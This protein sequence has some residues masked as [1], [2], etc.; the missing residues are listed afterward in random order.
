MDQSFIVNILAHPDDDGP[1]LVFADWLEEQGECARSEFIR[2]QCE[3]AKIG[4]PRIVLG[5]ESDFHNTDEDGKHHCH[6]VSKGGPDYY[7]ADSSHAP[8]VG[9][10]VDVRVAVFSRGEVSRV[11]VVHGLLVRKI[12]RDNINRI[13]LK[14]DE[15]SVPWP[16]ADL[17]RR[18]QELFKQHGPKWFDW[19]FGHWRST[20]DDMTIKTA[21][22]WYLVR[23][24]F[25]E[26]VT[27][28]FAAWYGWPCVRCAGTGYHRYAN[29][30][31]S[32]SAACEVCSGTGRCD[33][34]GPTL[35]RTQPITRVECSDKEPDSYDAEAG[36]GWWSTVR[37]T[38]ERERRRI[39][40]E[41]GGLLLG[42]KM[43]RDHLQNGTWCVWGTEAEANAALSNALI[44]WALRYAA[45]GSGRSAGSSEPGV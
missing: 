25:I 36:W 17:R 45:K 34:I 39:P 7:V 44:R 26:Q 3:L 27:L 11:R 18:E 20:G 12:D 14:R 38:D 37:G 43:H 4:S 13:V 41:I 29:G 28:P 10:R 15:L 5:D 8:A 32:D 2:I 22:G 21:D 30:N 23:R 1:R 9:D 31:L 19:V 40:H 6:L 16:G 42:M 24:G 35:V 33:G